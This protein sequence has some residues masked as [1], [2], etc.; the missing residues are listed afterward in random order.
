MDAAEQREGYTVCSPS[1]KRGIEDQ[2]LWKSFISKKACFV[3]K[4]FQFWRDQTPLRDMLQGREEKEF[5]L[6]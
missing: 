6:Q 4:R 3:K 2:Y 1:A 5:Q